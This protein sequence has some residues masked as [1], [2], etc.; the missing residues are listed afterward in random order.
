MP[1]SYRIL[2]TGS[3]DFLNVD[4]VADMLRDVARNAPTSHFGAPSG[5]AGKM[6]TLIHGNARGLDKT[7]ARVAE[8]WGWEVEEYPA[9]WDA[10]KPP[11]GSRRKNPAGVIRN[12]EMVKAGADICVAFPMKGSSGTWDCLTKAFNAGIPG[13]M[14]N[15]GLPARRE[16]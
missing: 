8:R 11:P 2:V 7:A 3:R 1:D 10:H 4:A 15:A 6:V 13:V 16:R 9:D 12:S 5:P 14:C